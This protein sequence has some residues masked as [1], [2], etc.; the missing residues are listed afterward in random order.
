MYKTQLT[1]SRQ[2]PARHTGWTNR[3]RDRPSKHSRSV[4]LCIEH[5]RKTNGVRLTAKA[6]VFVCTEDSAGYW[7]TVLRA[8]NWDEPIL[9]Y[10]CFPL[11]SP[12]SFSGGA[13]IIK[14]LA[15]LVHCNSHYVVFKGSPVTHWPPSSLCGR[16][17][18]VRTINTP[19]WA[20]SIGALSQLSFA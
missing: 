14:I 11:T 12:S 13:P 2:L 6:C 4:F 7:A 1:S 20:E 10:F 18:K 3:D 17:S 5:S 8:A 19:L 15:S 9:K 16:K